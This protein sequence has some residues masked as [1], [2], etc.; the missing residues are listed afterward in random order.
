M[1]IEV[2][3]KYITSDCEHVVEILRDNLK[4]EY[5]IL[6]IRTHKDTG[7]ESSI[8]YMA[9]GKFGLSQA[10]AHLELVAEYKEPVTATRWVCLAK[11]GTGSLTVYIHNRLDYPLQDAAAHGYK[12]LAAKKITITEGEFEKEELTY[13]CQA[14][15]T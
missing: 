11:N 7:V 5:P 2:G 9:N 8:T 3:K 4:S 15:A 12:L 1:K 14:P 6:G 13:T 10:Y